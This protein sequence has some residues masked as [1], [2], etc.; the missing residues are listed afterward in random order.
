MMHECN[1]LC[2]DNSLT[3]HFKLLLMQTEHLLL[4]LL[5][6][7]CGT[8]R[9]KYNAFVTMITIWLFFILDRGNN[10]SQ[11]HCVLLLC[12]K[13]H[14]AIHQIAIFVNDFFIKLSRVSLADG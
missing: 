13:L 4:L 14:K 10:S 11:L 5:P 12:E 8:A 7:Y 9:G 6:F 3:V 2:Y 1:P